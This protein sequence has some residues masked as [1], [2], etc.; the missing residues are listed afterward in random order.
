[1]SGTYQIIYWRDIP[2]QIKAKV[3]RTRLSRP[4]SDRFLQ[5]ID[6]AA[7][8]SGNTDTEAYLAEW[9]MSDWAEIEGDMDTF[10]DGLVT[11]IEGNYSGKRLSDLAKNGGRESAPSGG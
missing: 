2:S 5:T 11:E 7:M 8:H 3:G 9:R 4:L 6:S 10:L 1:M